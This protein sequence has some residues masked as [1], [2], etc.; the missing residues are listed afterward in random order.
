LEISERWSLLVMH[1][2]VL[3]WGLTGILGHEI[4]LDSFQLVWWRVLIAIAGIGCFAFYRNLLRP[5]S[6][7]LLIQLV[8]CGVVVGAHWIAFF[9]AIKESTISVAL[10]ALSTNS[11]F[12]ALLGPLFGRGPW[13]L[14]EFV[15]SLLVIVGLVVIFQF[16]LQYWKGIVLGLI[17]SALSAGFSLANARFIQKE[18]AVTISFWEMIGAFTGVTIYFLFTSKL[19]QLRIPNAYDMRCLFFLGLVCTAFALVV[20]VEVMKRLS[21]FTCALTINLEPVYTILLA[22]LL[23]GQSEYMSGGF[24]VGLFLILSTLLLDVYWGKIK[25]STQ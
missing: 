5:K 1:L 17:A 23:Y 24:Y 25:R 16:E 18:S 4:S 14:K 11:F 15:L 22:L 2:I 7:K 20:S 19:D 6:S 9:A 10:C 3:I 21:P 12:V 13:R 8:L